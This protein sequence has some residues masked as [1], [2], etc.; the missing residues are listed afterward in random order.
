M[1]E[2]TSSIFL[3]RT[4]LLLLL[5]CIVGVITARTVDPAREARREMLEQ[6]HGRMET[7]NHELQRDNARL[8]T[9][10]S[11]LRTSGEGWKQVARREHGMIL[12]G[13][14]IFRFPTD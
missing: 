9:E 4:A 6:H 11:S 1:F 8:G 14:V 13:E 5:G 7:V 2:A 10:L 12:D 3:K